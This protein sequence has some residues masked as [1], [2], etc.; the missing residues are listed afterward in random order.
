MRVRSSVQQDW[1][2]WLPLEKRRLYDQVARAWEDAY[3]MLSVAL[4]DAISSREQGQLARARENIGIAAK[5]ISRLAEPLLNA[6]QV[7]EIRARYLSNSP[8]V[9][10]LDPA[11]FRTHTA[12]QAAGWDSLLHRV[13]FASRSRYSHKLR[14]LQFTIATLA[15]EFYVSAEDLSS[16][17]H[18]RPDESWLALDSLHYDLNTCLRETMVLLKSFLRVLPDA[19]LETVAQELTVPVSH[20]GTPLPQRSSR[21]TSR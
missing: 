20:E 11:N 17:M 3:A 16:G 19:T 8:A 2:A 9:A 12:R 5:L 6:C 7:L 4:N 15:E 18:T 10:P 13:L 21:A 1:I 14:A